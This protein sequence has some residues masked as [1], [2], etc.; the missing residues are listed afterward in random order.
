MTTKPPI[1]QVILRIKAVIED[2]A[3]RARILAKAGKELAARA[4]VYPVEGGYNREP[5]TNK[6]GT[7]YQ[8]GFGTRWRNKSGFL[9]GRNESQDLQ[10][11]WKVEQKDFTASVYTSVTYAPF[12][13][14]H[15]KRV[16]WAASHGWKTDQEIADGF[17]PRYE[18]IALEEIDKQIEKI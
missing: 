3:A 10:A 7:W 8:R 11:S 18:E 2:A 13:L 12:L 17:A 16:S 5:G 1:K 4:A 15:D 6:W 9:A 14:D